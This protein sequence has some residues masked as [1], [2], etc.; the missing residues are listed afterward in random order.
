M[1]GE[2]GGSRTE[3]EVFTGACSQK[4]PYIQEGVK[5][6]FWGPETVLREGNDRQ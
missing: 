6:T 3:K 1:E 5:S 2:G 4:K